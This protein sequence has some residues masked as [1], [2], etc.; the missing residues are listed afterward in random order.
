MAA[1]LTPSNTLS[2]RASLMHQDTTS[3]ASAT[4]NTDR[5]GKPLFGQYAQNRIPDTDGY[6]RTITFG[7]LNIGKDFDWGRLTSVTSVS[8]LGYVA[9]QDASATLAG[10]LNGVFPGRGYGGR[11]DQDNRSEQVTQELRLESPDDGQ[12][13]L[14]WRVGLFYLHQKNDTLQKLYAVVPATGAAAAGP[15]LAN[16]NGKSKATESA[17]FGTATYHFTRA[18]DVQVGVRSNRNASDTTTVSSGV[19]VSNS[20]AQVNSSTTATT[21]LLTP[22]Y[23]ISSDL[24]VYGTM[25][26]GFRP[27]GPTNAATPGAPAAYNPDK[28]RNLELGV[29]GDFLNRSLSVAAALYS[30]SWSDI[31]LNARATTGVSFIANGGEAKSEGAELSFTWVPHSGLKVTGNAVYSKAELTQDFL[32]AVTTVGT[33][34]DRLPFA[35]KTTANLSFTQDFAIGGF[36]AYAGAGVSFVGNRM[37]DFETRNVARV[38]L[39]GYTTVDLQAGLRTKNWTL[40][41]FGKNMT[42][43]VGYIGSRVTGSTQRMVL[44]SPRTLGVSV[45]HSM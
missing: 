45:S 24:M 6:S 2:V 34:G 23:T 19:I 39:A 41:L 11:N 21:Y 36:N 30:I 5:S 12:R 37:G 3:E 1:L 40:G 38:A 25:A 9:A 18:F 20:T 13:S 44:I 8:R 27:G 4:I 42:D 32:A 14:D 10:A 22:R 26:T 35:A 29:K 16:V 28:S 7:D 33:K 43:E 31:Q 17:A 15:T